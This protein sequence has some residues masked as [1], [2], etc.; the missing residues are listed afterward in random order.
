MTQDKCVYTITLS[1]SEA[2]A[3]LD[4][5]CTVTTQSRNNFEASVTEIDDRTVQVTVHG[6]GYE[7]PIFEQDIDALP[8]VCI[9]DADVT[10]GGSKFA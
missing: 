7:I 3:Y 4:E 10:I 9:A 5:I 1:D 8:N 6:D 2:E